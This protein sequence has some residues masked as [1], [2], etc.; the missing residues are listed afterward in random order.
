MSIM[1]AAKS[2]SLKVLIVE[3]R[4]VLRERIADLLSR[5]Q[6]IEVVAQVPSYSLLETALRETVPDLV[7][8]GVFQF[9]KFCEDSGVSTCELY[10]NENILLYT[11]EDGKFDHIKVGRLGEHRI[12]DVRRIQKEVRIFLKER[13]EGSNATTSKVGKTEKTSP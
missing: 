6:D 3:E 5:E 13:S 12:L 2:T 7:L 4:Y 1:Q 11:D 10:S 9:K 8:G